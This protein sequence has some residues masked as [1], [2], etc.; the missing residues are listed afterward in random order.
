MNHSLTHPFHRRVASLIVIACALAF[1]PAPVDAA[2]RDSSNDYDTHLKALKKKTP[3]GFTIIV[4][5]PFVVIGDEAADIVRK[6]ATATIRWAV[7]RLKSDY[8]N[9]DPDEIVDIWLFKNR[10]SYMKHAWEIFH[11]RPGTPYGYYSPT[12]SSLIMN[13]STGG[14][15]LIHE[16]VHPFIASNFPNCP[17]WFNEGLASLYEQCEDRR[18]KIAGLPNWRLPG[19]QKAIRAGNLPSF[20]TLCTTTKNQTPKAGLAEPQDIQSA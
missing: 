15:T 10:G 19:L 7:K 6:R 8:F 9:K 2:A 13:I 4:E 16:I 3:P 17:S 12:H 11:D 5:K 14:G 1:H 20:K 18:G